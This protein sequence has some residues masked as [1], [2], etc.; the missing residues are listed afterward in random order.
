VPNALIALLFVIGM[1]AA[2]RIT[3]TG[4]VSLAGYSSAWWP[5]P[6]RSPQ[7]GSSDV[8]EDQRVTACRP[9]GLKL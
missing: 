7:R 9:P 1:T 3:I 8:D 5:T 2:L 4:R 6:S